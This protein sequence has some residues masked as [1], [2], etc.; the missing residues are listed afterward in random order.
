MPL[1]AAE[2]QARGLLSQPVH[3]ALVFFRPALGTG[4]LPQM[5]SCHPRNKT[6]REGKQKIRQGRKREVR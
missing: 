5:D 3:S 4:H 6:S 2:G 1:L